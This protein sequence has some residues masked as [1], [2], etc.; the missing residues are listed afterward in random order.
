MRLLLVE[1]EPGIAVP[2]ERA[3]RAKG[4]GVRHA[5]TLEAARAA[6][7]E[8]EPDLILLDIQLPDHPDGGFV[9]AREARAFGYTGRILFM[10]ARDA[11]EDRV[12]GLDDGGDDYVV[13]PFDLPE[14]FARV[15]ALLR[16]GT[17]AT[18][19]TFTRSSLSLDFTSR[20]ARWNEIDVNL[21]AREFALLERLALAPDR[22]FSS[23]DLIDAVWGGEG[24]APS[25][26]KVFVYQLRQKL[27]ASAIET[28]SRGYRLGPCED[29]SNLQTGEP[30]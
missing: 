10:T 25:A 9:L 15:R 11:S 8:E 1:D 18:T 7:A 5:G 19:A 30:E 23:E 2:L 14:V 6:L 29:G 28:V 3:L 27:A 12:R 24:A 16:R 22:V 21:T 20:S 26:V 4:Y 13:K 17:A